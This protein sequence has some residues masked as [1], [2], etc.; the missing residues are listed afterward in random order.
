[1][2]QAAH[3]LVVLLI[4]GSA[5]TSGVVSVGSTSAAAP[6]DLVQNGGFENS[7]N[8][9]DSGGFNTLGTGSTT[10]TGWRVSSG[11]VDQVVGQWS[12]QDGSVSIDLSGGEPGAIEQNITGLEVGER[13]ELTYYYTGQPDHEGEYEAGVEIANL[14]ITEAASSSNSASSPGWTLATHNFTAGNTTET[15]TFTQGATPQDNAGMA[16]DNVSIVESSDPI[17]TTAPNVSI[18]QPTEGATLTTTD[19]AL[20][21]SANESGNWTY[22]VDGGPNQTA[23]DANGTKTLNVT[24]SGL[25]DGSHTATVSIEDDGGNVG[26]DTVNFSIDT[27]PQDLVQNG[28][29][30]NSSN[31]FGSDETNN[32]LDAEVDAE[33]TAI[34]GWR[35]SSGEV[36]Q[37]GNFWS[38]QDGFVSIDLTGSEPGAIEQ[39]VTELEAE[40][41]YELTYYYRN[42]T[43]QTRKHEARVEIA[44]LNITETAN[45]S[46]DWTLATHNFIAGNT[47]EKLKFTQ[48]TPTNNKAGM[49]ID[50]VSI[51]ESSDPIDTTAP[52]VSIDQPAGGA[53]L[54][55]S[56]VSLNVSANETGTWTYSV[57]GGH[58]QTATGANGTQTL[59]GT[60]ST[61]ADGSTTVETRL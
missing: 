20:N 32:N 19:V 25:A 59:N 11:E 31:N 15:L 61:L 45:S 30:E 12:P 42:N 57:D 16:I 7:S 13:Y 10:I 40:K 9:F 37:V 35:V 21:V 1:M 53:T 58:N 33:S 46:T 41:R 17:D 44:D 28:G 60:L 38:P 8:N 51:V 6:S 48:I 3:L 5:A 24:L 43:E 56:N 54:T 2:K 29:F 14:N 55:T 27:T 47:T 22:S 18:D 4:I 52:N 50:N 49:V 34:D 23:T 26:T 39:D 36:D